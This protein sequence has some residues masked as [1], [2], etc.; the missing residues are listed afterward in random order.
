MLFVEKKK[1][2]EQLGKAGGIFCLIEL[3]EFYFLFLWSL[4]VVLNSTELRE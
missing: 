4:Y 1:R 2:R 3:A